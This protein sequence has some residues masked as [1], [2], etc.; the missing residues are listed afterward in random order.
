MDPVLVF[1]YSALLVMPF[2]VLMILLPN[3]TLTE[4]LLSSAWVA[5]PAALAYAILVLPQLAEL[6]PVLLNPNLTIIAEVL[7]SPSGAAIAWIHFLAF[8]LVAGRW[9]YLDGQVHGLSAWI[10]SP[11]LFM[12]LMFGPLGFLLYLIARRLAG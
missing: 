12:T 3:W 5:A 1:Q 10:I 4:R 2:W 7:G 9:I 8:D 6:F 11:L